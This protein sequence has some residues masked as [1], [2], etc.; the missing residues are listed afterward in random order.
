M[1]LSRTGGSNRHRNA[2]LRAGCTRIQ[3]GVETGSQEGL[4]ILRKDIDL[5]QVRRVFRWTRQA[6]IASVAYFMIGLPHERTVADIGI[7]LRFARDLDPD[8]AMFNVFTPYP[9]TELYEEAIAKGI[10]S[11]DSWRNFARQPRSESFPKSGASSFSR[12]QLYRLLNA[13]YRG[14]YW[15]PVVFW[16]NVKNAGTAGDIFRKARVA[17]KMMLS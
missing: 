4:R 8:Y 6:G 9:G 15:R 3:Y 13:A 17:L 12:E 14:F 16:R 11:A 10:L 2:S 5:N 7:T 1:E